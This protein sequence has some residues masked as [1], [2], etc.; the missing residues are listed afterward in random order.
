MST[1]LPDWLEH[2]LFCYAHTAS[3]LTC[4]RTEMAYLL[5]HAAHLRYVDTR[6]QPRAYVLETYRDQHLPRHLTH[7]V[8]RTR[9]RA[10]DAIIIAH[11]LPKDDAHKTWLTMSSSCA[12]PLWL[13]ELVCGLP[14]V[15][16]DFKEALVSLL[17][18]TIDPVRSRADLD[19]QTFLEAYP[20]LALMAK[21]ELDEDAQ[22][23]LGRLYERVRT[24]FAY[25]TCENPLY[26]VV[27]D[28]R[29]ILAVCQDPQRA[30]EMLDEHVNAN[31]DVECTENCEHAEVRTITTD[32]WL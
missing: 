29:G 27:D 9:A 13:S 24:R 26:L 30:F 28:T 25:V 20:R 3:E 32:T 15:T 6:E 10:R 4:L 16:D 22:A 18:R 17:D 5:D 12:L 19:P 1:T 2:D 21:D 23:S 7:D 11:H 8:R 14:D 31:Y